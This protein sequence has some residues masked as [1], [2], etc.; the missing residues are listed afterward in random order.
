MSSSAQSSRIVRDVARDLV[1]LPSGSTLEYVFLHVSGD[2]TKLAVCLHPWSW[3]GGR[4]D[5]PVLQIVTE[6]LLD[7]GYHVLRYNSRGV[8]KSKG[9]PSLT[10]SQ[11]VEDLKELVQWARTYVPGL[12]ELVILG[13]S[14]GSLIASMHPVL[15]DVATSHILLSYP[16][17][18]RHWLTAFHTHRYTAA[19]QNLINDPKSNMLVIYGDDDNF[20]SVDSYNAWAKGLQETH[21]AAE[22][23]DPGQHGK[24]EVL[25][26]AG[27]SHFW[28]E[29]P[30]V[31]SLVETIRDWVP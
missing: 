21:H 8:G 18:P 1:Q 3:L 5:D 29:A 11:E 26:I 17:G 25:K 30:A 24:L 23:R 14:H 12:S 19:L 15:P 4:M 16:L 7:R 28:R 10:G 9:W 2:S 22:E 31:R 20:T 6:P 13:Y 27:A